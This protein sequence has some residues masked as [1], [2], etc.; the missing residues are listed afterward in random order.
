MNKSFT[1]LKF[2]NIQCICQRGVA[3]KILATGAIGPG[4]TP[5]FAN[6]RTFFLSSISFFN[7]Y[8]NVLS[9]LSVPSSPKNSLPFSNNKLSNTDPRSLQFADK[10]IVSDVCELAEFYQPGFS[11][12][13]CLAPFLGVTLQC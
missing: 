1:Y 5:P 13:P 7:V 6:K 11:P 9:V 8:F 12:A 2:H 4:S 3:V 10:L